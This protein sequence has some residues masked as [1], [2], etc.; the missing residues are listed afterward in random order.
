[1]VPSEALMTQTGMSRGSVH[2]CGLKEPLH[3]NS[4]QPLAHPD[5]SGGLTSHTGICDNEENRAKEVKSSLEL[6]SDWK[7]NS[8][9]QA[10]GNRGQRRVITHMCIALE[11]L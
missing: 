3:R 5:G 9:P 7:A 11:S 6:D 1:M 2:V 8:I 10:A 4:N